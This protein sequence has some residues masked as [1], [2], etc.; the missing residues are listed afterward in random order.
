MKTIK[1]LDKNKYRR[2]I[3]D[4]HVDTFE[5]P[6]Q[7]TDFFFETMFPN[8]RVFGVLQDDKLIS[9]LF[10]TPK[11]LV[12]NN[13]K[14]QTQLLSDVCTYPNY[15]RQK[16]IFHLIEYVKSVFAKEKNVLLFLCPVNPDIY[17]SN[18][19]I[20]FCFERKTTIKYDG[21]GK[22]FLRRAQSGDAFLLYQIYKEYMDKKNAYA[23]RDKNF[24]NTFILAQ[25]V[26]LIYEKTQ[27][28]GYIA[29]D[30]FYYEVCADIDF[31]PVVKELDGSKISIPANSIEGEIVSQMA[32][33]LD[34]SFNKENLQNLKN[35]NFD[36]YW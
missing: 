5:E 1:E 34:L 22:G 35:V 19:F 29:F 10:A 8:M 13:C 23:L 33:I 25:R 28:G 4:L 7:F 18:S 24:F 30:G 12:F 16:N 14:I 20:P 36:R 11:I 32:C 3:Y 9:M 31:L 27:C 2:E 21:K 6:R 17:K 26:D 15:R